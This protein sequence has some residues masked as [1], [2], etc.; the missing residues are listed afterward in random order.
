MNGTLYFS[1]NGILPLY[2][3]NLFIGK[4]ATLDLNPLNASF[5]VQVKFRL[6]LFF[7]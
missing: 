1:N 2:V 6:L 4:R 5:I 3:S 7:T